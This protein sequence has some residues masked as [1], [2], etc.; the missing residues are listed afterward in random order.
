[1]FVV[2][3]QFLYESRRTT[4]EQCS[5]RLH[6]CYKKADV[7]FQ[8][9]NDRVAV[10]EYPLLR[11]TGRVQSVE[12]QTHSSRRHLT[13]PPC[14]AALAIP[15]ENQGLAPERG[16]DILKWGVNI[17]KRVREIGGGR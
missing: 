4:E 10:T 1:M 16:Y 3:K 14:T 2:E 15:G 11:K 9:D 17:A 7:N 12:E 6:K 5:A 8:L 13:T